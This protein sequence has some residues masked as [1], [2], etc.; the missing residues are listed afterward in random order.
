VERICDPQSSHAQR[1]SGKNVASE[2][3]KSCDLSTVF[4]R[5][6]SCYVGKETGVTTVHNN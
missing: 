1:L 2:A 4:L 5:D 6:R 3:F